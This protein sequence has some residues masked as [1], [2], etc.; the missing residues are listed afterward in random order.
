[1]KSYHFLQYTE[2]LQTHEM[3][4][5]KGSLENSNVRHVFSHLQRF[6]ENMKYD[7]IRKSVAKL[8]NAKVSKML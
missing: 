1:M 5:N 8:W 7:R 3:Y 6:C 2:V 4:G